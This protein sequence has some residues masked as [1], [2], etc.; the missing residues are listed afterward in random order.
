MPIGWDHPDTAR[1]YEAFNRQQPRYAVANRALIAAAAL[2]PGLR[3]LDLGAGT[4][5]TAE[6]VLEYGV[7]VTCIEPAL[8]MRQVGESRVPQA[9]WIDAWPEDRNAFDRVLCGASIWQMLPLDATF[10]RAASALRAG[11]ALVFNIPSLYLG[12]ADPPG[13]EPDPYL[14]EL[15]GK[16]SA[17][18]ALKVSPADA[19]PPAGEIDALLAAAGFDSSHWGF[20]A[21]L[22]QA[23]LRDW[24]KIPVLTDALLNGVPADDRASLVDAAYAQSAIPQA[25][26]GKLGRGGRHGN[27]QAAGL[28]VPARIAEWRPGCKISRGGYGN[29]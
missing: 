23:E 29:L 5:S 14:L 18:R 12:E 25:G 1:Y 4:G 26:G 8:A 7:K 22:T 28:L 11:G 3:V 20:R 9:R 27:G 17:G 2:R 13:S 21:R 15:V 16:L 10:A 24:M 6:A 19:V